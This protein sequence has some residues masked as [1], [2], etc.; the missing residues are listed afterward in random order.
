M[1]LTYVT[2]PGCNGSGEN[3]GSRQLVGYGAGLGC[4]GTG[5]VPVCADCG[6][7]VVKENK[8]F[9]WIHLWPKHEWECESKTSARNPKAAQLQYHPAPVEG[10]QPTP[11]SP[12]ALARHLEDDHGVPPKEVRDSC[13]SPE[14]WH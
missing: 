12:E 14:A 3:C 13:L 4:G 10:E 2:C 8:T 9:T 7:A 5:M 6:K 11:S 1:S